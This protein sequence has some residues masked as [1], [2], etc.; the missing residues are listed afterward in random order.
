MRFAIADHH[1]V[2]MPVELTEALS[3]LPRAGSVWNELT[4]GKRCGFA[5]QVREVKTPPTRTRRV[6]KVIAELEAMQ[7]VAA[8]L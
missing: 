2:D 7:H 1:A 8:G 5:H 6:A 4:P 3:L